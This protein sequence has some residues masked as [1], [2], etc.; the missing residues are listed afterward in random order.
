ML[1]SA[2]RQTPAPEADGRAGSGNR[3]PAV[4]G[5][6]LPGVGAS[7]HD[8]LS[9]EPSTLACSALSRLLDEPLAGTAPVAKSW[10]MLEQPGPWGRKA[11]SQSHQDTARGPL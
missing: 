11:L 10:I 8:A 5:R 1:P 4:T 2:T 7:R 6:S 3:V 9:G